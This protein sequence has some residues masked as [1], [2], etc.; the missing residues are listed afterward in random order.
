MSKYTF[1][2]VQAHIYEVFFFKCVD[3]YEAGHM[4]T[5]PR[6]YKTFFMLNLTEHEIYPAHKC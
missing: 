2:H 3:K 4:Q 6:H 1:V 5:W